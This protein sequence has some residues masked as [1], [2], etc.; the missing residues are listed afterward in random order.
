MGRI[1][2]CILYPAGARSKRDTAT[3]RIGGK[4]GKVAKISLKQ[5]LLDVTAQPSQ[6]LITQVAMARNHC[7]HTVTGIPPALAVAGRSDLLAGHA[8][9]DWGRDPESIDRAA[10]QLNSMRHILNA[11]NAIIT[12]D[13]K[14]ALATCANRNIPDRSREFPPNGSSVQIASR[15]QWVGCIRAVGRAASNL[16][17]EKGK[18]I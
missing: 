4:S 2:T 9:T 1:A 16:I 12:D 8:S 13:E 15:N 11:R 14:R 6:A 18:C 3:K 10:R 7:P 5:L 17:I